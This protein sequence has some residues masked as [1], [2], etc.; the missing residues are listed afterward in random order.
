MK[1]LLKIF[2][3]ALAVCAGLAAALAAYV[4]ML[5]QQQNST[6]FVMGSMLT[7]TIWMRGMELPPQMNSI[8]HE[9]MAFLE[10]ELD[11]AQQPPALA[12][13]VME[14]SGG[15]FSP[16]MG[17]V[18]SLWN[19][20][21]KDGAAPRV[22]AQAEIDQALLQQQVDLGAYGKGAACDAALRLLSGSRCYG[23]I[24]NLGGNILTYGR[25]PLGQPFKIALRD[26]LGGANETLGLFTLEGT[27][28][29]STSGSYEK[30]FEQDGVRYHHI[31]DPST[32]RPAETGGLVSVTVITAGE[33]GGALGDMLST[34]CF[35]LGREASLPL[36]EQYGGDA[37][38]LYED[39]TA[40]AAGHAKDC[41]ALESAAWR[42]GD[43]P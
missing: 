8:I 40:Y 42:W 1:K 22:P 26:P 43:A 10:G 15:A 9:G 24:I 3:V 20:S 13:E 14:A 38:F 35:V 31:F 41:F 6:D 23:A 32:G 2:L 5:P 17:A 30:F 34:A 25:K 37:L 39:G 16:Y 21:G 19:I 18:V 4:F 7:Q 27:H 36:L 11:S 28:C 12:L 33:N 29:I